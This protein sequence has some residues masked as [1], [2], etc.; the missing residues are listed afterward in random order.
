MA[1]NG[2]FRT[3]FRGFKKQDV[4]EYIDSLNAAHC[5]EMAALT[6]ELATSRKERDLL[7]EKLPVLQQEVAALKAEAESGVQAKNALEDASRRLAVLE[8]E[9][10]QQKEKLETLSEKAA[11]CTRLENETAVLKQQL[12]AQQTQLGDYEKL[13]GESRHA[14]SFVRENVQ[15]RMQENNRR[16]ERTLT[17]IEQLTAR[18]TAQLEELRSRTAAVRNEVSLANEK[19]AAALSD[20]FA[21][22][23]KKVETSTDVH[24][25]R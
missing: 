8:D 24:F 16:T 25:F 18:M 14:V 17:E 6:Q 7:A 11:I 15:T 9:N 22:F 20:W 3:A 12:S 2:F 5:D 1:E 4:L 10:R 13:F 21:Q 23:D 19:D